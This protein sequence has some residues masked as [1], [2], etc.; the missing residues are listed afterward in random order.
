MIGTLQK[1]TQSK[2]LG[3]LSALT[4]KQKEDLTN[5]LISFLDQS[6]TAKAKATTYNTKEEQVNAAKQTHDTL[7][8]I[9]SDLYALLNVLGSTNFNKQLAIENLLFS[10]RVDN[11]SQ[12][13]RNILLYM[14]MSI[15]KSSRL[16][17]MVDWK[18]KG[19]PT[20]T[21]VRKF[22]FRLLFQ[23]EDHQHTC[24]LFK[25]KVAK[26]MRWLIGPSTPAVV[27][28]MNKILSNK[29]ISS[30][31][32]KT[33]YDNFG[34]YFNPTKVDVKDFYESIC[35]AFGFV[36][37]ID[38]SYE[39]FSTYEKAKTNKP[40]LKNLPLIL[41]E[42]LGHTYHSMTKKEVHKYLE[43][44]L[45]DREISK[46]ATQKTATKAIKAQVER[47]MTS[48]TAKELYTFFYTQDSRNIP[49]NFADLCRRKA[50]SSNSDNLSFGSDFECMGIIVDNSFSARGFK[51]DYSPIAQI[52]PLRDSLL[53]KYDCKVFYTSDPTTY[54]DSQEAMGHT[55]EVK[56]A[57]DIAS[58]IVE[59]LSQGC[60]AIVILTDGYENARSG[61]SEEVISLIRKGKVTGV[62]KNMIIQQ[63][64]PVFGAETGKSRRVV[65]TEID[66][67]PISE[68]I[69]LKVVSMKKAIASGNLNEMVKAITSTAIK[70]IEESSA[71]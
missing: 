19:Y 65:P 7:L 68:N 53:A 44:S 4:K 20:N 24:L 39:K 23:Y 17:M 6:Q 2:I 15:P 18:N 48:Y 1:S 43:N 30:K 71:E 64:T 25:S 63:F 52:L 9:S 11:L 47:A 12:Y 54:L 40:S 10:K 35:F 16:R 38:F 58:A 46:T 21:R 14:G 32:D 5:L 13:E 3:E 66:V 22:C 36:D 31:S 67:I 45:S 69:D 26:I 33:L 56:G 27:D 57:T 60:D 8:G 37:G 55:P 61:R 41:A 62:D 59:A 28:I 70:Q 42:G 51:Q 34:R 50:I 29:P 49:E